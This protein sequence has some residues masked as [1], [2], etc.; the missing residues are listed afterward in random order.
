MKSPQTD[1][2]AALARA[3]MTTVGTTGWLRADPPDPVQE[4][5]MNAKVV[6]AALAAEGILLVNRDRLMRA[7]SES[8]LSYEQPPE[9]DTERVWLEL[10]KQG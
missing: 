2:T 6:Q 7:L 8:G 4:W 10:E 1:L 9:E 3:L 5:L